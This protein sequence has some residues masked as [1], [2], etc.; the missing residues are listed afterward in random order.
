LTFL[1]QHDGGR[2]GKDDQGD[3][4]GGRASGGG[5]DER[6]GRQTSHEIIPKNLPD[7][8]IL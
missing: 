1:L 2:A 8:E 3:P 5:R 7:C 4:A 6:Q